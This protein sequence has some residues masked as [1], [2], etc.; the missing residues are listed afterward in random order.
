CARTYA[1]HQRERAQRLGRPFD[2][3]ATVIDQAYAGATDLEVAR[4]ALADTRGTVLTW[5][6]ELLRAYYSST[7]GG[8]SAAAADIWPTSG[9]F[10]FNLAAPIQAYRRD[11]ACEGSPVYTWEVTRTRDDLSR[12]FREWGKINGSPV[13]A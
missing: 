5:Q 8:R 7:C 2:L 12:R 10:A 6:G 4:R 3:E 9:E 11:H 1:L 13:K